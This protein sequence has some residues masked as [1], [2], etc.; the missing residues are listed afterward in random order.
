MKRVRNGLCS[1]S[2]PEASSWR[3]SP[4]SV[5]SPGRSPAALTPVRLQLQ[6]APQAQFA[7][8]FAAAAKGYYAAEGLDVRWCR[9]APRLTSRAPGRTRMARRSPSPGCPRCSTCARQGPDASDLVN[10]AQVFQRSGTREVS[11]APGHGPK[12]TVDQSITKPE[13]FKGKKIGVWDFGD[14]YEV[15]AA[16]RKVGLEAGTD[17]EQVIQ[18]FDMSLL[19]NRQIDAAEAMIYNEYR[20]GARGDQ[21]RHGRPL[22]A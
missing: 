9:A 8:Y 6:W 20:P 7:G 1:R 5:P 4:V 11:W 18:P 19:L 21:P 13:D 10:I 14:D 2:W 3:R 22:P 17:Y 12:P 16:A 15:I